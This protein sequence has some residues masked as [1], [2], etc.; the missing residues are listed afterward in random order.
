MELYSVKAGV[1]ALVTSEPIANFQQFDDPSS[2]S[3]SIRQGEASELSAIYGIEGASGDRVTVGN[4]AI[5]NNVAYPIIGIA[6]PGQFETIRRTDETVRYLGDGDPRDQVVSPWFGPP[7]NSVFPN[8]D[9]AGGVVALENGGARLSKATLGKTYVLHREEPGLQGSSL[10][11]IYL[12][13]EF[14]ATPTQLVGSRITGMG[15]IIHDGQSSIFIALIDG[16]TTR[17]VGLFTDAGDPS[18][19]GDFVLPGTPVDWSSPVRFRFVADPRRNKIDMYLSTD[20]KT[21]IMSVDFDRNDLPTPTEMGLSAVPSIFAF[22]H[23]NELDPAGSFEI[24]NLLYSHI[25]QAWEALDGNTPDDVLT[26]PIWLVATSGFQLIN[27]L[28]GH[29]VGGGYGLTP[30][31][32]YIQGGTGVAGA[33]VMTADNQL[34]ITTDPGQSL[35]Y[36]RSADFDSERG[37]VLEVS[38]QVTS[39]KPKSRSGIFLVLDDGLRA[40]M[41]SFVDTDVGKFAGVAV[42]AGLNSFIES[43]GTDGVPETLS[44]RVDWDQPH[45]YRMERRPLDG[46]YIFV[47]NDLEPALVILDTARVD[48]PSSQFQAPT[49]AFG[50]FSTE[51]SVSLW[52]YAR[53]MWGSGYEVSFKRKTDTPGLEEEIRNSQAIVVASADDT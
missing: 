39:H 33:A 6:R 9:T 44:F 45:T 36:F 40:Y 3:P 5:T 11:G 26:D 49:A 1:T 53:T 4:V 13:T 8:P 14:F 16:S 48:Y 38:F 2:G 37:A 20:I 32:Y 35:I 18:T 22:G 51:G 31:G 29:L 41:L 34:Q 43:V 17:T 24:R 12:E 27:P 21:P 30:L 52:D 50:V 47:D 23:I 15:F 25:Y 28:F 19:I 10:N 46:L 42:R 7:N